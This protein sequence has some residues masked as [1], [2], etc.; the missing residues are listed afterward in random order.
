MK[1]TVKDI[2]R[3]ML[4][5]IKE[6]LGDDD[7]CPGGDFPC[8]VERVIMLADYMQRMTEQDYLHLV[9]DINNRTQCK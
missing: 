4:D 1:K 7:T 5:D 3:R 8:V 9:Y 6:E 2:I